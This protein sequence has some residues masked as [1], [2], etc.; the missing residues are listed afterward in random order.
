MGKK[1]EP[2][3]RIP[4]TRIFI[5]GATHVDLGDKATIDL[6]KKEQITHVFCTFPLTQNQF[7]GQPKDARSGDLTILE[8]FHRRGI[9]PLFPARLRRNGIGASSLL[10]SPKHMKEF[11]TYESFRKEAIHTRKN[12]LIVCFGG[13]HASGSY[14]MYYLATMLPLT[15]AQIHKDFR[16]IGYSPDDIKLVENFFKRSKVDIQEVVNAKLEKMKIAAQIAA[17]RKKRKKKKKT[18]VRRAK[19]K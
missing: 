8:L 16:G 17:K 14:A 11:R 12:F 7:D 19:L 15:L 1:K 6:L 2:L 10:I 3:K 4:G 13:W 5:G 18:P 9:N